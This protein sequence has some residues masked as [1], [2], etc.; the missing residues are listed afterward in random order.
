LGD[1]PDEGRLANVV[2]LTLFLAVA[3]E[4]SGSE[5]FYV[6]IAAV[7]FVVWAS[8]LALLFDFRERRLRTT[9]LV[10]AAGTVWSFMLDGVMFLLYEH[11]PGMKMPWC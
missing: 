4:H 10:A 5:A 9:A 3:G 6:G 11:A 7:R 8:L 2:D 1:W